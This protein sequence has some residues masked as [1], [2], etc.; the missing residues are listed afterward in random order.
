MNE[1]VKSM[2]RWMPPRLY[3]SRRLGAFAILAFGMLAAFYE[4]G[5]R[6]SGVP[7]PFAFYVPIIVVYG[8]VGYGILCHYVL[9]PVVFCIGD[10][11]RR[12]DLV[13]KWRWVIASV[14][15]GTVLIGGF[16]VPFVRGNWLGLR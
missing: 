5:S 3:V 1:R 12:Y 14:I 15:L 6:T 7:T 9:H 16:I 10:G 11:V 2:S 8:L 4:F 13:V